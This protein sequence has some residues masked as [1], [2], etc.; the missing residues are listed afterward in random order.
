MNGIAQPPTTKRRYYLLHRWTGLVAGFVG[1]TVFF[2]GAIATFHE[3][4]HAWAVRGDPVPD[5]HEV[6]GFSYDAAYRVASEDVPE[7]YLGEIGVSQQHGE[8]LFFF[9]HEHQKDEGGAVSEF[10]V[11][12]SMDPASMEVLSTR[13]GSGEEVRVPT[14]FGALSRFFLDLHIF[15]LLPRNLGLVATGLAGF[16]L[17]VLISTGTLVHRP[18]RAKLLRRPR[19]EDSRRFWGELHTLVGSW[20]LPYTVVLALTG[21]F[22][23]FAGA[24]LIP[25]MAIVAFDGDQERLI[26]TVIGEVEV[27]ESDAV[28]S[29]DPIVT[30]ALD[31]SGLD[32][33]QFLSLE[34]WGGE[35]AKATVFAVS[36]GP[37]GAVRKSLVYDGHTGA[38]ITEKPAI[39]TTP[40]LGSGLL[41]LMGQLHFGTLLGVVTKVLWGCL[42]LATCGIAA[43]GLLIYA[44]RRAEEASVAAR[45]TRT[46][47]SAL[48]GGLPLA[49]AG[50]ALTWSLACGLGAHPIGPMTATFGVALVL[51]GGLGALLPVQKSVALGWLVTA[52]FLVALPAAAVWGTGAEVQAIWADQALRET[53]LVDICMML[54]AA[55]FALGAFR[56]AGV[57]W[58]TV[59]PSRLVTTTQV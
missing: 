2:S 16:A 7:R 6:D 20:T 37:L 45:I 41:E 19:G 3:E 51:A 5:V 28:A 38:F 24:V 4:I 14:P 29:L 15:L 22:F 58:T 17:L 25:L 43:T 42:G 50:A 47:I 1:M 49:A 8:P 31:R 36:E 48:V 13:E 53:V 55:G 56:V 32:R 44:K 10:G 30:D 40:S 26:R 11:G 23:S 57:R 46:S 52:A 34:G 12:K 59:S 18:N 9:F 54:F 33:V 39:G 21:T 35:D 27:S